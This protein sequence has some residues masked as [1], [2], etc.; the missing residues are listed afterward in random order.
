MLSINVSTTSWH[1][2]IIAYFDPAILL[3]PNLN[4]CM[5]LSALLAAMCMCTVYGMF[6][7]ILIG[8]PVCSILH[9]FGWIKYSWWIP[10]AGI[11]T[12]GELMT[13]LVGAWD[14]YTRY[15]NDKRRAQE[16]IRH[17]RDEA[18]QPEEVKKVS[19]IGMLIR[20]K[21]GKLCTPVNIVEE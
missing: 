6:A 5:Y 1:Y 11:I 17:L 13:L 8:A 7:L 20:S 18:D 21:L 10:F 19:V 14:W 4:T 16:L 3:H 12:A 15:K 9:L 2:R